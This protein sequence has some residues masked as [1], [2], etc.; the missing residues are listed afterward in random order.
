[1]ASFV[2]ASG[3]A[4]GM[5]GSGGRSEMR[6]LPNLERNRNRRYVNQL[7]NLRIK[8][9]TYLNAKKRFENQKRSVSGGFRGWVNRRRFGN[10]G[11]QARQTRNSQLN[12]NLRVRFNNAKAQYNKANSNASNAKRWFNRLF[13]RNRTNYEWKIKQ[14]VARRKG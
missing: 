12:A 13:N 14:E 5:Q 11:Q 7:A 6:Q 1:M 4:S 9:N 10:A 2:A 8:K 3:Y